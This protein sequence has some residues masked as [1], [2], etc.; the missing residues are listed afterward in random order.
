MAQ[1]RAGPPPARPAWAGSGSGAAAACPRRPPGS[2]LSCERRFSSAEPAAIIAS[3][4]RYSTLAGH[5]DTSGARRRTMEAQRGEPEAGKLEEKIRAASPCGHA[6]ARLRRPAALG[7]VRAAGL[8]VTGFDLDGGEG[9]RA[10]RAAILHPGRADGAAGRPGA[11]GAP[12]RPARDFDGLG[13]V[14]RRD[15]LRA[16]AAR[17]DQGPRPV[18]RRRRRARRSPRACAPDSSWCSRARPIPGTT[19]ELILPL[20]EERGLKVGES[21]LPRL[22]ARARR[23]GQRRASTREHAQDRRRRRRPTCTR[24]GA[25]RSTARPS[26][27]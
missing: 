21:L 13:R 19:E 16:H 7:R 18:H 12:A 9:G 8:R 14:R 10:Q 20:L 11:R 6:R 4:G 22:L 25:R 24:G 23:P 15:H 1:E 26:T 17:Q 2:R 5:R 3:G 27:P